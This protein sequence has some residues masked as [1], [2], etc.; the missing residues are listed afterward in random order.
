VSFI[1]NDTI[2]EDITTEG[3]TM[4]GNTWIGGDVDGRKGPSI[5]RS[6]NRAPRGS[7]QMEDTEATIS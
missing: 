7:N 4:D 6:I 5:L 2:E 3:A 1:Q